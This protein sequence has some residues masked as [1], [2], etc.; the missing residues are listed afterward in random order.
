MGWQEGRHP[1]PLFDTSFYLEHNP[2]V[3][4]A[5]VNPLWHY[6]TVGWQ[7]G[8]NPH[9]LFD[10]AWY[11]EHNPDI[12]TAGVNPLWHYATV[13]WQEGRHPHPL[14]DTSF[15]LEHNPDVGQAGVNPLEHYA[16]VGWQEGRNPHPLFDTAFYLEH[17]PDVAQAGVNPLWHFASVGW[18]EG[19]HPH[20]L[21][22][23]AWYMTHNPDVAQALHN[24]LRSYEMH[25]R[26]E[27]RPFASGLAKFSLAD[28]HQ[29]A[30][31]A[32]DLRQLFRKNL[33]Q[34]FRKSAQRALEQ[35]LIDGERITLPVATNPDVS[36]ILVLYN[37][38]ELTFK[39][40]KA[41][42]G[43]MDVPTELIVVDNASTDPT[44]ELLARVDGCRVFLQDQN[45]HFLH[46]ANVGA[47]QAR[48]RHVLFL[49]N[50]TVLK[51]GS[52]EA[53]C[54]LLDTQSDVGA[55]GGK[56]I[57]LDGTVQEAGNIIWR[58][59]I[60]LGYGR[61]R[62]PAD[63]EFQFQRDVDYC[64][65]AFLM[66][67]RELFER[68]AGFDP[69]FAPA[70]YEDT[71]LCMRIRAAGYR[72]VYE[73][74]VELM[75]F[76]SG[77]TPSQDAAM[78][79]MRRN[80]E[81]FAF[82]HAN[83]L[84]AL[85]WPV[86][87]NTL[88][89]RMRPSPSG[90]IL[91]VDDGVPLPSLGAGFPRACCLL[92]CLHEEGAFV[93]HYSLAFPD[94]DPEEAAQALPREVEF[95]AGAGRAG[96]VAFLRSRQGYYDTVIVSRPHNM[97]FFKESCGQVPGFLA[98]TKLV[99]DA[100]AVFSIREA[101]RRELLE[102]NNIWSDPALQLA[103][104]LRLARDAA[105]VFTVSEAEAQHFRRVGC[106]DV[107][108]L[109]H[110]LHITPDEA[111]F[112]ERRD[113]LFV[114]RLEEE[115]G[116]NADSMRWFVW[117]VMPRLDKLIGTAYAIDVVGSCGQALRQSL[118]SPRVRFH[119]RVNDISGF[120]TSA[121]VF[122][123]PTR[124]AAGLPLKVHEAAGHGLPVVTTCLIADQ[125]KWTDGVELLS[126][127]TPDAFARNCASV[128]REKGQ[129]ERLRAASLRRVARDCDPTRFRDG[130]RG[131]LTAASHVAAPLSPLSPQRESQ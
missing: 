118:A 49:N 84:A 31:D 111:G 47:R 124:F 91:V 19:R 108:V 12:A 26:D 30:I 115:E 107:R 90:R 36:V 10:S 52:L 6:A 116:P 18:Q 7:E 37:H 80:R 54:R 55:V 81:R 82:R 119:G 75:R 106:P 74:R 27:R 20:P 3:A 88:M 92:Q 64:S 50:D 117:E 102:P 104:E 114:G 16:T 1:H 48:G 53:A 5:G 58:D 101:T 59:G 22:E 63:S 125:L 28:A 17:N 46:G 62:W 110:T 13:G 68:L 87:S 85:H 71:D 105:T 39:C 24:A 41:M 70:Y 123:A 129:W 40:L 127:A 76:E 78:A 45:L 60:C 4:Q 103:E 34:L 2:D 77:S 14:F 72:V 100:E 65:G 83:A 93:T 21:F 15:Y 128:Y 79:L 43:A 23:N 38:A 29:P 95:V 44:R 11:L 96:M 42:A 99:Y 98:S 32:S 9:P 73:P 25:G 33:R 121:R 113:F 89:A 67:R 126:A 69:L 122:V 35:F 109:G 61:G 86:G 56:I 97:I 112:D 130:I 8:R 51:P 66:V 131:I 94:F 57:L 120:Y